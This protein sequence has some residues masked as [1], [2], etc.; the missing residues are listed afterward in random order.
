MRLPSL[1][2]AFLL[3]LCTS[4]VHA[5]EPPPQWLLV[6][7]PAYHAAL[8]PLCEHR[9]ADGFRVAVVE[10]TDVLTPKEILTGDGRKL[11]DRVQQMCQAHKGAS[12]ILLVGAVEPNATMG[13]PEK[14]VLPPLKGTIGR[15]KQQPSDHGYGRP[16]D[17]FV[18]AVPVGRFPVRTVTEARQMVDKTIAFEKDVTPGDWRRRLTVLAGVPAFNPL[19]DSLVERMALARLEG[20]DPSWSGRAIYHN[21]ASRF[22]VPDLELH[23]RRCSMFRKGKR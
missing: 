3:A 13:E 12:Y 4:T 20:I 2:L 11:R 6:T 22:C 21:A 19:I 10:T 1:I 5:A 17:D 16:T 8:E 15:M 9:K 7:A 14:K 23:A 18:D